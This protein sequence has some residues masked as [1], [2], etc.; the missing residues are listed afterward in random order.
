[1]RVAKMTPTELH[2]LFMEAAETE[3]MLP[4][5]KQRA[6]LSWWPDMQPEWLA[7]ADPDTQ[8][9]LTPSTEQV[10]RYELAIE[11]SRN[12]DDEERRLVWAVAFS[13]VRRSR[14]PAWSKV[15]KVLKMDARTVKS[16]Y[17][18]VLNLLWMTG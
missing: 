16:R 8:V 14:G 1:M 11:L 18:E 3:A 13:G 6:K 10:T 17:R 2:D 7:Y 9:K 15:G 5:A 4:T 12:L